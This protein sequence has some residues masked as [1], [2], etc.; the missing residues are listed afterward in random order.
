MRSVTS[1]GKRRV[2]SWIC[3]DFA[4]SAY[5][6]IIG[7]F[8]Y[9]TLF[10]TIIAA[11]EASGTFI[12]GVA[13]AISSVAIGLLSPVLGAI[14]DAYSWKRRMMGSCVIICAIA[15]FALFFPT[16]GQA[17]LAVTVFSIGTIAIELAIVFNNAFLPEIAPKES[18]GK[19]SGQAF[20]AGYSGGLVCL[21]LSLIGFI[22]TETPWFGFSKDAAQNVR[23]TSLLVGIWVLVFSLPMLLLV[24]E[25]LRPRPSH[26]M[27]KVVSSAVGRLAETF[28]HLRS[29]KNIFWLFVSRIFYN[30]ALVT[31]FTFGAIYAAGT[32]Q[33]S[34][35]QILIFGVALN[36]FAGLGAYGFSFLEDRIGSRKTIII[37]LVC[38][39]ASSA[40][41]VFVET[42]AGFW[43]C[44]IVLGI[45]IGPN[46]S[47]SR[48]FL[49]RIAPEEKVNEFFGFFAFSGKATSFLGPLLCGALTATYDSQRVG[50]AI[51]PLLFIIGL[52]VLVFK[53][54]PFLAGEK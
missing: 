39:S 42:K 37:S 29:Y 46:Q 53:T 47:A 2:Y 15:S 7:T 44:A 31:A 30:D 24:K 18:H 5:G 4:N 13:V 38:L 19:V 52:V 22:D 50:M 3:F 6:T 35:E 36:V 9:A 14:A 34:P 45:F 43:A 48:A 23:A 20:A 28:Q 12:W 10:T 21:G 17:I 54:R 40:A 11:D 27:G 1:E 32:F 41:A 8:V 49:S 51:V 25:K 33:F 26:G 16:P